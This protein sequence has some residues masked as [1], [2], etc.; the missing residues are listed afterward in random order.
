[1]LAV[2]AVPPEA[3]EV[4]AAYTPPE[5]APLS[6]DEIVELA[7]Q[8]E[9][10]WRLLLSPAEEAQR[11]EALAHAARLG[12]SPDAA[13]IRAA[14]Q[15]SYNSGM[16]V[17]DSTLDLHLMRREVAMTWTLMQD[18]PG[19]LAIETLDGEG[20]RQVFDVTFAGPDRVTLAARGGTNSSRFERVRG[21]HAPTAA[22]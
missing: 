22:E 5:Q 9:G 2:P 19:V 21:P 7:L 13:E 1:M 12:A 3:E 8:L 14:L 20:R 15:E 6:P 16:T 4:P 10:E 17:T 18:V 11:S